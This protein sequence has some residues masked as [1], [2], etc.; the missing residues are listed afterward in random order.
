MC[1]NNNLQ[2]ELLIKVL[3]IYKE[4]WEKGNTYNDPDISALVA[5]CDDYILELRNCPTDSMLS[6][7]TDSINNYA[8][9]IAEGNAA[10]LNDL[11]TDLSKI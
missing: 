9:I 7:I 2:V 6:R 1:T 3:E 8:D 5:E 4:K 10:R 11:I